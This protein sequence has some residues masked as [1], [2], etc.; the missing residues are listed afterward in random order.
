MTGKS[1]N[2]PAEKPKKVI[3]KVVKVE[4]PPKKKIPIKKPRLN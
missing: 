1:N 4:T 2:K 3:I